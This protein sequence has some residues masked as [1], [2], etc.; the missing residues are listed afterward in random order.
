MQP[1]KINKNIGILIIM[2]NCLKILFLCALVFHV[3]IAVSSAIAGGWLVLMWV[4][5][6]TLWMADS[7]WSS[8]R[9]DRY[10]RELIEAQEE[11]ANA[12]FDCLKL[13]IENC[14]LKMKNRLLEKDYNKRQIRR[15]MHFDRLRKSC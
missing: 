7:F 8:F 9:A 11:C 5:A 15:K 6:A 14:A 13:T 1:I 10:C 2:K 4:V 3:V 12:D